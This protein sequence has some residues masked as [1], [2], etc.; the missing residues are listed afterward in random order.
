MM[1]VGKLIPSALAVVA[2]AGALAAQAASPVF[3]GYAWPEHSQW[4]YRQA[5][6]GVM[7]IRVVAP[8]GLLST[9]GGA[10]PAATSASETFRLVTLWNAPV[11]I[12]TGAVREGGLY[13]KMTVASTPVTITL[14][15]PGIATHSQTADAPA[16][17]VSG[18]LAGNGTWTPIAM[19]ASGG[20]LSGGALDVKSLLKEGVMSQGSLVPPVPKI[21]F[22]VGHAFHHRIRSSPGGLLS[23]VL[24]GLG[25]AGKVKAGT[26]TL[27]STN[28][29]SLNSK[30]NWVIASQITTPMPLDASFAVALPGAGR[31]HVA[32]SVRST[33]QN[34]TVLDSQEGGRLLRVVQEQVISG[35]EVDTFSGA[36]GSGKA[37]T[38][39]EYVKANLSNTFLP[40][41]SPAP[42]A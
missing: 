41:S 14:A 34:R 26:W 16:L 42:P 36:K 8:P 39:R 5:T 23:G 21:G 30:G 9:S 11:S 13:V 19:T 6:K 1:G 40:S 24:S 31:G 12:R 25:T 29:P 22:Q 38:L 18:R 27:S 15:G 20:S 7:T 37:V 32:M 33:G 35:E 10:S 2:A 4:S 17:T 28:V 3:R